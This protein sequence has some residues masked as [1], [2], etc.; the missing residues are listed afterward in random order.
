M[1]LQVILPKYLESSDTIRIMNLSLLPMSIVKIHMS[2][3]LTIEKSRFILIGLIMSLSVLVP[4]MIV[5]GTRYVILGAATSF[6]MAT[7]IQDVYFFT[8]SKKLNEENYIGK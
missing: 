6:V 1:I 3:F 7:I 2:K 5:F 8:V 4:T